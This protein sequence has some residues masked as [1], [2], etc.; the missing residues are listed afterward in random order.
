MLRVSFRLEEEYKELLATLARMGRRPMTDELRIA[1]DER[2]QRQGL[3]P[4]NP[5]EQQESNV[6]SN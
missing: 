6:Q 5:T 3:I 2:A 4:V 1:I